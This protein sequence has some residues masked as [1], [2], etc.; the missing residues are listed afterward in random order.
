MFLDFYAAGAGLF[1]SMFSDEPVPDIEAAIVVAHPGDEAVSA[2]WL[3]VRLR[4][5]A[6]VY[7]LRNA[8]HGCPSG[9]GEATADCSSV[10]P[11]RMVA[12][13]A[14]AGVPSERCLNLGLSER[15]L[16]QD[17]ETLVWLTTAAVTALRPHVLV[18]HACEGHNLDHDATAFAVHMTAKLMMRSGGVA[19]VVVEVPRPRAAGEAAEQ[20]ALMIR[21]AVR[22]EFGPE[23]R[24]IKRR[25]L[26]CHGDHHEGIDGRTLQSESYVLA[27]EG[28][29]LD[30]LSTARG[31]YLDAPW[32][33]IADFRRNARDVAASLSF[34]VL[35]SPSRA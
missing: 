14:L 32:C 13:A 17:L 21:Q 20:D 23:S 33:Q 27:T 16:I 26:Q 9:L 22:I 3:M 12:A 1:S 2:S 6:A 4:Q 28:N 25:M 19:P 8:S 34:A 35:S 11:V 15:E 29:P 18:T 24:K 10:P 7:C 31:A 5:R 30:G